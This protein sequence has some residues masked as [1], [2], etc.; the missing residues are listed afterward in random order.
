VSF[1]LAGLGLA[2]LPPFATFLGKG[3]TDESTWA[4]GD[5]PSEDQAQT[6]QPP[7]VRPDIPG[8]YSARGVGLRTVVASISEN[9][10]RC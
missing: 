6:T 1:T 3:Y 4:H 10:S 5:A 8:N 7:T 9:R 2:D